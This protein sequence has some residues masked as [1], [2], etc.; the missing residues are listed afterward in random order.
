MEKGRGLSRGI[1]SMRRSKGGRACGKSANTSVYD[2]FSRVQYC[3]CTKGRGR[4]AVRRRK[5]GRGVFPCHM[6]YTL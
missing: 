4:E 1:S 3:G 2:R 5:E 6:V